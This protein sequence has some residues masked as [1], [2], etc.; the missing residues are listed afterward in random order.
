MVRLDRV[1]LGWRS[2]AIGTVRLDRVCL[3]W[4][5]LEVS[6]GQDSAERR[7]QEGG[8]IREDVSNSAKVLEVVKDHIAGG[9]QGVVSAEQGKE[10]KTRNID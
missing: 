9:L 6:Y 1:C 7:L 2:G 8:S 4:E 3:G 5:S 10:L